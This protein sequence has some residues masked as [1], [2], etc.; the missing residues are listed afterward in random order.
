MRGA[1]LYGPRDVRLEERAVPTIIEPTDAIIRI[2]ATCV[3]GSDLW[4]YRGI[5]PVPRADPD[6]ARVLRHCRGGRQRGH[7][8]K[9]QPVRHRVLLRLRQHRPGGSVGYLASA[10][11]RAQR[12]GL[13]FTH[14]NLH[15]GPAPVRRFLPELINLVWNRKINPGK[16]FDLT[17]PLD[18]ARRAIARWTSA[19]RSRR[20]CARKSRR[21][22][23]WLHG[24]KTNCARSLRPMTCLRRR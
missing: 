10:R 12:R 2:S 8:D 15:G 13:F 5:S 18:R 3:C 1:I 19:A 21:T 20:C 24:R 17:L 9:T 11:S 23:K 14:V 6:G 16:V 22:H 7:F 4:P